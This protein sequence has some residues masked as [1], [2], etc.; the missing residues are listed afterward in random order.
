M[1]KFEDNDDLFLAAGYQPDD[2]GD[3][4]AGHN[5]INHR[6]SDHP[7]LEPA[8]EN[9]DCFRIV[10]IMME[11]KIKLMTGTSITEDEARRAAASA[12]A[13]CECDVLRRLSVLRSFPTTP[14]DFHST[15]HQAFGGP[16]G[17]LATAHGVPGDPAA[18]VLVAFI[19]DRG[20]CDQLRHHARAR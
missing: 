12:G 5:G 15:Y 11:V 4:N 17:D 18:A 10:E 19:S 16:L 7:A 6:V 1:P 8:P 3:A 13:T 9:P 20:N 2:V 14:T